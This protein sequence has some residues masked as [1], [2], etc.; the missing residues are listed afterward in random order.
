[1]IFISC[2]WCPRQFS[3]LDVGWIL[4]LDS[5]QGK[6]GKRDRMSLRRSGYKNKKTDQKTGFHLGFMLSFPHAKGCQLPCEN[7]TKMS[8]KPREPI[9][10]WGTKVLKIIVT[11]S[12]VL[13]TTKGIKL[14]MDLLQV[15]HL[16]RSQ[17]LPAA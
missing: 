9:S 5:T 6:C 15:K 16:K 12:W 1:M 13:P 7:C 8:E 17:P 2:Y 11:G 4:W 14:E 10:L 3:L